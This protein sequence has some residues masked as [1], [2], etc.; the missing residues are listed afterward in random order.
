M[1]DRPG[2]LHQSLID[3]KYL[4][5]VFDG[6]EAMGDR[7]LGGLWGQRLQQSVQCF[8]GHGVDIGGASVSCM[9]PKMDSI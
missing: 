2:R 4:V 7:Y 8:F 3:E 6:S 1:M 9:F 5:G